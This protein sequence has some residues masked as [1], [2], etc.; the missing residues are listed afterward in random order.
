MARI[1]LPLRCGRRLVQLSRLGDDSVGTVDNTAF[2]PGN[3]SSLSRTK[4]EGYSPA[5][6]SIYAGTSL[7]IEVAG[8]GRRVVGQVAAKGRR[9]IVVCHMPIAKEN[10]VTPLAF[11]VMPPGGWI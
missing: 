1:R 4:L 10:V 8:G 6:K 3:A 5:S 2:T 11:V 9:K 7:P